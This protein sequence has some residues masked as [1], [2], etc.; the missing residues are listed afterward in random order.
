MHINF[1]KFIRIIF[2]ISFAIL[3]ACAINSWVSKDDII[4]VKYETDIVDEY[5]SI[6]E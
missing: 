1:E 5:S 2:I 6:C 3:M 4:V